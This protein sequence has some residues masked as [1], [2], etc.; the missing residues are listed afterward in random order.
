MGQ[1]IR[2][3]PL[4]PDR[5]AIERA[6]AVVRRGGVICYPT[7]T[8]YGLG[9]LP[10]REDALERIFELK[11]RPA[12]KGVLVLIPGHAW[13]KEL[14]SEVPA[15]F[16][17]LARFWPGPVTFLMPAKP[18]LPLLVRGDRNLV[19]IRYPDSPY[20]ERLMGAIPGPLVST[21]ANVSGQVPMGSVRELEKLLLPKVDLLLDGG[22]VEDAVPSSV[23]DLSVMPPRLV[24]SGRLGE[25]ILKALG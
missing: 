12:Q 21:S 16:G 4:N 19:G 22:D 2:I 11:G 8:I 20:L 15:A 10:N 17:E 13:V 18:D 6:A 7:D 9:C 23:V 5:G 3:H 14:C 1:L 25:Q 24:R